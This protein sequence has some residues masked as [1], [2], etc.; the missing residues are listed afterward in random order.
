MT[1]A[2]GFTQ[3]PRTIS[4]R[5]TA[6]TRMSARRATEGRSRVR[7]W[8]IVTVQWRAMQKLRHRLAD[9]VRAADDNRLHAREGQAQPLAGLV[10]EDHR[11]RRR[12]GDQRA[13]G[14]P[15]REQADIDGMKAVD[16]LVRRD[17]L[18]DPRRIDVLGQRQLHENAVHGGIGVER[19]DEREQL[20]F[21]RLGRQRVL[22]RMEAA[23]PGRPALAGDVGLA[24]RMVADQNDRQ[25]RRHARAG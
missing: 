15:D 9:D 6:A 11:A 8:A 12:A 20:R 21:A 13:A 14:V 3:F 7:E 23:S 19:L 5:P 22:D 17:R 10:D 16:V 1:I 4:G 2:P 25:A 24:R 18:Q